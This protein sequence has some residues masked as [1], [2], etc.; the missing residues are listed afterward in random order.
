MCNSKYVIRGDGK[1]KIYNLDSINSKEADL[2]LQNTNLRLV[3]NPPY[4]GKESKDDPTPK[5]ITFLSKLLD[6]CSRYGVIIAPLSIVFQR[7]WGQKK[8]FR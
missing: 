8:D 1:S 4:S 7:A 2:I 5:E 3:I 6:N